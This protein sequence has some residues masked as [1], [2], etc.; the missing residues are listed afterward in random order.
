MKEKWRRGDEAMRDFTGTWFNK[1]KEDMETCSQQVPTYNIISP[2]TSKVKLNDYNKALSGRQPTIKRLPLVSTDETLSTSIDMIA[3]ASTDINILTSV[4]IHSGL[5]PKLTSNTKLDTTACLVAWYT[6]DR[7][8]QTILED[9][10]YVMFSFLGLSEENPQ[11]V[12]VLY[13]SLVAA[14]GMVVDRCW[15]SRVDRRLSLSVDRAA[16]T[17]QMFKYGWRP[18]HQVMSLLL[19]SGL[20]ASRE[21]AVKEM[22]DCPSTV[23]PCHRSMVIPDYRPSIYYY[24]LKPRNNHKL[25]ECP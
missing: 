16:Q 1:R 13:L 3:P 23:H 14:L 2:N 5:E 7:I 20:S 21:E 25:P 4:D 10:M 19:K 11:P 6:W 9:P 17:R 15:S 12:D 18:F 22:K 24:R 8:L